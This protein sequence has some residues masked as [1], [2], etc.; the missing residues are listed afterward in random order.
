LGNINTYLATV[1]NQPTYTPVANANGSV[2]LTMLTS[3][4]GNTGTGGPLTDSDTININITAVDDAPVNTLPASYATNEDTALK[5]SGLSVAD[6][7]AGAGTIS[8]TLT[9][10][11]GVL[12]ATT[13]GSVTVSGSG[14]SSIVLSGTLGN[15]NTYLATVANQPTYTPV[16]NANGSV[17]LTML[18]SDNGNTGTGGALT[19]SDTININITAVNDA[20]SGADFTR[21]APKNGTYTFTAADFGFTDTSDSPPNALAAVKI[22]A[23]NSLPSGATFKDNGVVVTLGQLVSVADINAGLLVFTPKGGDHGVNGYWSFTFQA[24]DNGGTANGGIDLDQTPNTMTF[25]VS[26]PAGIAGQEINLGLANMSLGATVQ[27]TVSISGVPSGW[28]LNSGTNNGDGTWIVQTNDPSTLMVTTPADFT[29][30]LILPVTMTWINADGSTG[31][32]VISNNVEAYAPGSPIFAVSADDNLTASSAADLLV[33]AQPIAQDV[34]YNFDAAADKID[35][36]G[37]TGVSGFDN[38]SITDDANGNA[39]IATGGGS[40]ITVDG[41]HAADLTAANFE[42]NVE[43]VTINTGTMTIAN[44]AILPLGG[45]IEN[46]GTIALGSTGSE[47]DLQILV[48][49]VTLQGGGHVVLSDDSNNVIFGGSANATLINVDNTISGAGQIGA[50]Q[51]ALVNAGTIIADGNH[52]LVIDTGASVVANSGTLEATGSGGLVVDGAV[53]G[54]GSLWANGGDVTIHGDVTGQGSATIS[55]SGALEFGAA[56][57]ANVGFAGNASGTLTVDHA[58]AF[59]GTL[60]G[61]NADDTLH[62]GDITFSS[63]TQVSYTA[64][65]AGTAGSLVVSDGTHTAQMALVGQY[66]A[67]DFQVVADQN[68]NT[69]IANTAT[70]NATVLGTASADVLVGTGGN[71]II[72]GGAGRDTLTGGAGHDTFLFRGSDAGAVDTITNFDAGAGA[73]GDVLN[74]GLLLQGYSS[75]ADLSQ[76][77]SL[78]E[79][80]DG[81]IVSIDSD[82]AGSAHGFQDL[83]LLQG[84]TGLDFSTL[85]AHVDATPLP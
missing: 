11:S 1:A 30:A 43:P 54:A 42:F 4:N 26:N 33:F 40:T 24:K 77:I 51:M 19:D 72:V 60:T 39:V 57:D 67:A 14:T 50:G 25:N 16:A 34:I 84:V 38:L 3:D 23:M 68:G 5:L 12:T 37:F 80:G 69:A 35:L 66:S 20:P 22:T 52:A 15:I 79:S 8:V 31:N 29:G 13:A 73:G 48:E 21:T 70:G 82:G 71:D 75:G 28:N 76:F 36:I 17:A 85:I 2:A 81:T 6:V 10:G 58:A 74:V 7:D 46:S 18:T 62:F 45:V 53:N 59:T 65:A 49:S 56:S 44:G 63:S 9:A 41:V 64:N 27:V 61:L 83:L 32:A 47:T 55:G 78:R